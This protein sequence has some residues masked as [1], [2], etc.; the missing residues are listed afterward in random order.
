MF[1]RLLVTE[2]PLTF[3]VSQPSV[4]LGSAEALFDVASMFT[5]SKEMSLV[6]I[7]KFVQQGEFSIVIPLTSTWVALSVRKRMGR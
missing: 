3:R 4:F 6:R 7:M 5:P 2:I 1:T